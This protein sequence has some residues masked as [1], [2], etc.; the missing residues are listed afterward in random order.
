MMSKSKALVIEDDEELALVFSE[1]LKAAEFE[2]EVIQDGLA[3]QNRLA[4]ENA[5]NLILLDL[6]L[7]NVDGVTLFEQ[8]KSDN[9][10]SDTKII[11]TTADDR[12]GRTL[13][14]RAS[15]VLLKPVDFFQ[16][17]LLAERLR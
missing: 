8:I 6:H 15:L 14:E 7:P 10:Y 17:R 1:A 5:P 16:L 12:L 4:G 3:A 2:T 11:V 9:R 13:D